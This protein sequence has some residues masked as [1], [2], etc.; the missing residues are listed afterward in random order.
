MFYFDIV[1]YAYYTAG[2]R[3]MRKCSDL[4]IHVIM[5]WKNCISCPRV[6]SLSAHDGGPIKEPPL[7]PFMPTVAFNIS[8]P[9]DC[10]SRTANVE[11]NSGHKWVNENVTSLQLTT[12]LPA[13]NLDIRSSHRDHLFII[14]KKHN[15]NLFVYKNQTS[16]ILIVYSHKV[17]SG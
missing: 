8:C 10:I 9:R 14:Y 11:R 15:C 6:Y 13:T 7:N 16:V 1:F 4:T 17:M 12:S 2:I 5:T 3:Y